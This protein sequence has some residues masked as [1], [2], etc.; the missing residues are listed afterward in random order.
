MIH[1]KKYF[2]SRKNQIEFKCFCA[3]APLPPPRPPPLYAW[4]RSTIFYQ[5]CDSHAFVLLAAAVESYN[6]IHDCC[7]FVSLVAAVESYDHIHDYGLGSYQGSN[8]ARYNL[9][10]SALMWPDIFSIENHVKTLRLTEH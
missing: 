9:A 7:G 5:I 1:C 10:T 6:Q 4:N 3:P 2:Q 8:F